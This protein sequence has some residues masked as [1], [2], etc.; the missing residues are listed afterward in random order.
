MEH[1][2]SRSQL[3]LPVLG[4]SFTQPRPAT[5]SDAVTTVGGPPSP[6][7]VMNPVGTNA[8][9]QEVD[10]EFVVLKGTPG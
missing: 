8:R 9:A 10:G 7:F 5:G 1:S 6:V 3:V 2:W 4:F